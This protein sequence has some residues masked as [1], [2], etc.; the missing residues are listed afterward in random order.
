MSFKFFFFAL[1]LTSYETVKFFYQGNQCICT[2]EVKPSSSE[3]E[4]R[5]QF[6]FWQ[7][8]HVIKST[9]IFQCL[10]GILKHCTSDGLV[11]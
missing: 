6:D 2:V 3:L 11:F 8:L 5:I 4:E 9:V 7:E 10:G 1:E